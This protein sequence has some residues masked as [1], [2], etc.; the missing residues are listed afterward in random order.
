MLDNSVGISIV[1]DFVKFNWNWITEKQIKNNWGSLTS[2]LLL[3]SMEG[4]T[5]YTFFSEF[6]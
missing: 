2:N 5:V 1:Q 3:V 6:T 4:T